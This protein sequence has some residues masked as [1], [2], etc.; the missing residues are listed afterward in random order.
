MGCLL[1]SSHAQ[2]A[3]LLDSILTTNP[4]LKP[5]AA[6][7][8]KYRLQV[9]YTR[10]NRDAANK[11]SFQ[12]HQWMTD[13]A[14]F[15]SASLVK[16]PVAIFTLEKIREIGI[17]ALGPKTTILTDSAFVCQKKTWS[18]SSSENGLPYPELYIR[19]MLLVSDNDAYSRL[20]EFLHP[21]YIRK[22]FLSL[23]Y[24]KER[25][26]QRF[27][28]TC[29]GIGNKYMNPVRFV[30]SDGKLIWEQAADSV[31]DFRLDSGKI[32]IGKG[33]VRNRK[34]FSSSNLLRLT[35]AHDLLRKLVFHEYEK[36]YKINGDEWTLLM[37]HMGMYP[38]ESEWPRYDEKLFWDSYKK[39]FI[40]GNSEK[41]IES[42]SVRIFNVVGQSYGFLSDCAY[43]VNRAA[44]IEFLLSAVIYCNEKDTFGGGVYQYEKTGFPYLKE[45]SLALYRYES[46]RIKKHKPDLR[47][48]DFY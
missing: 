24:R 19:K 30:G 38:R 13:S 1:F 4:L 25:I 43:I 23:G 28:G 17:P 36:R 47:F 34:D 15:Y 26:V 27:D 20:L 31:K 44:G 9:I 8:K 41:R 33:P 46:A 22:R 42:D 40:Y 6:E 14:Y 10:I 2:H 16:L 29:I 37:K 32:V 45:L 12:D 7:K 21:D 3:G 5:I 35:S 39:Y 18:D 11:P 48:V